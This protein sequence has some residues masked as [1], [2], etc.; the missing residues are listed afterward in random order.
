MTIALRLC[1]AGAVALLLAVTV[2]PARAHAASTSATGTIIRYFSNRGIAAT[3]EIAD[4]LGWLKDKG[5]RIE[6]VGFSESGPENLVGL[7]TGAVDLAGVATPPLINAIANG[8]KVIGVM[9]DIGTSKDVNS[10]F[11]VLADST[12]NTASNLKNKTI[13]VNTLGAHLDYTVREFARTHGLQPGDVQLVVVPGPQLDQILRHKQTDVVAVGA[14]QT[15]FAGKIAAEGGARVL[16]TDYQVLGDIVLGND[17]MAKSFVAQHPQTVRDFV[18]ASAR[19]ADWTA[20]H[21]DEARKLFAQI[22]KQRGDNPDLARFWL[23]YG[24][25]PHALYTEHDARFWIDALVRDGRLKPGQF[26]PADIVTN[27]YNAFAATH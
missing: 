15:V 19:A 20:A 5:I 14:W 27:T 21:P 2:G 7:T 1:R 23:G 25:R 26:T 8:A 12:I 3:Y 16:F 22:L 6:S 18:T 24:V 11:F 10:K 9:P 4:A 17:A 13:A